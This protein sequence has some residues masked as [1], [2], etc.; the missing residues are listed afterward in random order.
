MGAISKCPEIEPR[1]AVGDLGSK[2]SERI[3]GVFDLLQVWQ[4]RAK[5]RRQLAALSD[6]MLRDI[7]V[8]ASDVEGEIRKWFWQR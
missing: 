1:L 7:G 2:V 5:Q 8:S 4:E 3:V 6:R